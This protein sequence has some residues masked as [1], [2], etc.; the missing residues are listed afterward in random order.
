MNFEIFSNSQIVETLGWTL[1][2][3]F[4]QIGLITVCLFAA[5]KLARK[6]TSNFRYF[7]S[8]AAMV[9]ALVLPLATFVWFENAPA[10]VDLTNSISGS[11]QIVLPQ[12]DDRKNE[13]F[14]LAGTEN[15]QSNGKTNGQLFGSLES[16]QNNFENYFAPGLPVLVWLWFAGVLFFALK[17]GGGLWQLHCFKTRKITFPG[18]EWQARFVEL[19]RKVNVSTKIK[20]YE[21]ALVTAPVV[22]G[23]LKPVVLVPGAAFLG[24]TPAQL[25]AVIVH[26]LMHVRRLD[27]AVNMAQALVE[28]VLFYHPGVWWISSQIRREREFVCDDLVIEFY[29]ERLN[30]AHALANLEQLRQTANQRQP[31]LEVAATGGRLMNRIQ[32]ILQKETEITRANSLWSAG[33]ALVLIS[34]FLM[35]IFSAGNGVSVNAE[36]KKSNKKIAIG[37]VSIPPVDRMADPPKDSEATA[38]LMIEKLK[39]HKVPAIGFVQGNMISDGEKLYPVRAEIV[40]MWRDAGLEIGVGGYKHIWFHD[41]SLDDYIANTEKNERIV[42]TILAEK[43]LQPRYFSYPF[44]NTGKTLEDKNRFENWLQT[45]GLRSV[46]YTFDNQEW[47]YSH[48]YDMARKDNDI[49]TMKEVRAEYLDYMTRMLDHYEAYSQEMFGRDIRQTMVLTT[50]RLVT[51][52]ADE[53]FGLLEKRGYAFVS[54]DEAQADEAYKTPETFAGVKAGISWFERWQMAR[55]KKLRDEPKVSPLVE[56]MWNEARL[57]K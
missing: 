12:A 25:E 2:H 14:T 10:G 17:T 47:M 39:A 16:W 46:K 44:L 52:T 19:C 15:L 22:V 31:Q 29:G 11:K 20:F 24:L 9:L 7:V 26:E 4:W 50:S 28:I 1:L 18:E 48:A 54:M 5:L 21:S 36:S 42:K 3:S 33:L 34:A 23:W 49:N 55:N 45:R 41:T 57:K 38:R 6:A 32:R 27:F 13:N 51:D 37:F 53:F 35:I 8:C 43:N 40:R 56:K 30:Y